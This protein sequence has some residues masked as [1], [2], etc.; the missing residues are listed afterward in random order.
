ELPDV[1]PERGYSPLGKWFEANKHLP[2]EKQLKQDPQVQEHAK[3]YASIRKKIVTSL[4]RD[5]ASRQVFEP[6]EPSAKAIST[7]LSDDLAHIYCDL[8]RGLLKLGKRDHSVPASVV[9]Q[10]KFG[11]ETHWGRHAV[12][13]I[14]ALHSLLFG[15]YAIKRR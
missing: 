11:L 12:S 1:R 10:W 4:G 7:T 9:W 5:Y 8:N 3:R 13:A 6:F 2:L 14:I 15:E